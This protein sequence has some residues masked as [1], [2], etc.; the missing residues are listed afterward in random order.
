MSK[1]D[2]R[3]SLND[4]IDVFTAINQEIF[5]EQVVRIGNDMVETIK[6]GGKIILFGNGGSAAEASHFATELISKCS[7]DHEPWPAISLSDSSSNLTA[8][9]NDYGFENVFSRQINGL[10]SAEDCVI[11]FSTSGSSENVLK[12]LFAATSIGSKTYLMTGS[13]YIH[14]DLRKWLYL[15]V[16]SVETTK[17]QEVHLWLIHALSEYCEENI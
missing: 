5:L 2:F 8:I 10:A 6:Q 12:A 7:S 13:K 9:G 4:H 17:I 16:P 3:Q 1:F 14:S 11:G 15:A